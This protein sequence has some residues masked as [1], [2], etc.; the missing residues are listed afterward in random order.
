MRINH[1]KTIACIPPVAGS[2]ALLHLVEGMEQCQENSGAMTAAVHPSIG[3]VENQ[4]MMDALTATRRVAVILA[5]RGFV[6]LDARVGWRN[7]RITIEAIPK[8]AELGGIEIQRVVTTEFDEETMGVNIHGVQ[9]EWV[10]R[11][12]L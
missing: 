2:R 1:E 7:S 4:G 8:C 6:V 12:P 9:V 3:G 10:S 5:R 11:R